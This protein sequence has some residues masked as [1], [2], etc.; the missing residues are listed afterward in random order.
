[1]KNQHL[2][3]YF[4]LKIIAYCNARFNLFFLSTFPFVDFSY[5]F[6]NQILLPIL[7]TNLYRFD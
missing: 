1:M 2:D 3:Q 4:Q 5:A 7:W 6:F